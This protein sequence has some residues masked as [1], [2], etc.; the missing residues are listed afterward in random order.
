MR[1]LAVWLSLMALP[2]A[3]NDIVYLQGLVRMHD[4]AAP[5][6]SA[7]ILLQCPGADPVRQ[8]TA[9]KNGKFY[10]KVE[11]D[12]FN[13]V[14]RALPSTATD[15]GGGSEAGNCSIAAALKGY[16]SS[17]IDLASFVIGKD[18]KLP[19]ITLKA[20]ADQKQ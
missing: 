5:G 17:S 6:K 8:T 16:E 9:G 12:D 13:H 11:R 4:G 19:P 15:V 7:E 20:K 14:A 3:A 18:L 1:G 10:L 2:L